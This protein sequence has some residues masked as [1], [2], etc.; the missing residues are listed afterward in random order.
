VNMNRVKNRVNKDKRLRNSR[1]A[2]LRAFAHLVQTHCYEDIRVLDI[3]RQARVSRSTFYEHFRSKDSILT[4]SIAGPFAVLAGSIR[5]GADPAPL[6][7]LLEHFWANR[8]LARGLFLGSIRRKTV[9]VLVS[10]IEEILRS[11]S[12]DVYGPLL[13]PKRLAAVQI[14]ESL[15]APVIAWL[16]GES[17]CAAQ[18]LAGALPRAAS[19]IMSALSAARTSSGSGGVTACRSSTSEH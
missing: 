10:Q 11:R 8:T 6:V 4:N 5:P 13:I 12:N 3:V 2:L 17:R 15:L 1:T 7:H 14:A 9:G 18:T 19:A 16:L